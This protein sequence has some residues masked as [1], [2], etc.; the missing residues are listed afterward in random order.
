M[1]I[2]INA[3]IEVDAYNI[4]V[5]ENIYQPFKTWGVEKT[6]LEKKLIKSTFVF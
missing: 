1:A 5:V 6:G 3:M 2:V 4:C